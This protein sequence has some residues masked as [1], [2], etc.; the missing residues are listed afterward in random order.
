MLFIRKDSQKLA[1]VGLGGIG[2]TQM[3]LQLAYW[4]KDNQPE[5]SV[6]WVS[7]LSEASF[8]Q[9]YMEIGK[10][11]GVAFNLDE[12]D[13]KMSVKKHLS[14]EDAGKWVLVVDN[15]DDHDI[16]FGQPNLYDYLPDSDTGLTIF[17]S[18]SMD[19]GQSVA[20]SD[21]LLCEL[22]HLPLAIAQ[23]AAYLNRNRSSLQRYLDLLQRPEP[24]LV[25]LMSREFQDS[26]RYRGS[27][28]AV[29]TTWLV[30][31]D[32]IQKTNNNAADLLSFISCIE[33]KAIPR[34]LLLILPVEEEMEQTIGTLLDYAF[35]VSREN[36]VYDMHSLVHLA[37][38][39]WIQRKG[40]TDETAI[41]ALENINMRLPPEIPQNKQLWSAY[42]PHA[43]RLLDGSKEHKIRARFDLLSQVGRYLHEDRRFKD[44]IKYFEQVSQWTETQLSEEAPDRL[45]AERWLASAFLNGRRTKD[46]IRKLE[47]IIAIERRTLNEEDPT[48]LNSE[49]NL[50]CAYLG[51]GQ[52]KEA[53]QMLEYIDDPAR[54]NSKHNLGCAY[55]G[56]GRTKDAI[57]ML[58]Y[59]V[60][61]QKKILDEEDISRL[62]SE[63]ELAKAYLSDGRVER[64]IEIL[65]RVV[66]LKNKVFEQDHS[67]TLRSEELLEAAREELK[68]L[69]R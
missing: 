48:R 19:V 24:E 21:I 49:H 37:T 68:Q 34:S 6:L 41:K 5:Y 52:T 67:S 46:A 50:A 54:L 36:D 4:V 3:A 40:R 23:A 39:V 18:R 58:E 62:S 66:P 42:L 63:H 57:Q 56:D 43:L 69:G 35:L 51:D 15:V 53:I 29:A 28:N 2:K 1:I 27:Q 11:F 60:A 16:L 38:R 25:S 9:A 26:T 59:I 13:P 32:Q 12:E 20:G 65:E 22:T 10:A 31:F 7:A 44:S 8:E 55:L 17:T 14:L 30:S 61:I 64:A 45:T 33:P 47:Y